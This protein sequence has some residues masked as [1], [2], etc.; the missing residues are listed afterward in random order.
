MTRHFIPSH[1]WQSISVF[2]LLADSEQVQIIVSL[3]CC[4]FDGIFPIGSDLL[5]WH[6]V[7]TQ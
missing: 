2:S 3:C 1:D 5:A 7:S 6:V 4:L